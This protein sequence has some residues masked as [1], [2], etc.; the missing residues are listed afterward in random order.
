MDLFANPTH[1]N[2]SQSEILIW[3]TDSV[4]LIVLLEPSIIKACTGRLY[5]IHK[6]RCDILIISKHI[7]PPH[8]ISVI[9]LCSTM[10][11]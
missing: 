10:N 1:K 4:S 5:C 11:S 6:T 2:E 7:P 8:F 3:R 9:N